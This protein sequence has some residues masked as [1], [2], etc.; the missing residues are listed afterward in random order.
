MSWRTVVISSNAKLDY[1]IGYMVVRGEKT[2]KI[3][4][5]EIGMLIVESTAVSMTSYLLSELMKNKIKVVFCDEK[6][7][8]CSELVSYYGSHDTSSKIRKQIEWTKDDKDHIWTEIVSEKIKQQAL[9]LQRYQKEEAN[10]LFE[11]MEEVEFGDITNREGHAAKVYFNT[12][13]GKKFTRTDENPINAALNYGY[14]IILSIFNREIVS[15]GYLTQIGLFHDNMFNQFNLSSDLMEPFRPLVDQL[16]VELK[17][18]KFE[19]EEKRKMLELLNKEVEICGKMEVVTNA[20]K[21]YCRSV[22]DALNDRDISLIRF[23]YNEL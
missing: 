7:N 2:T 17:P 23:Y 6:R 12:L 20:I 3:H 1:Q 8:P 4:L 9:M 13:F 14:G 15:S 22:F 21:I 18:E 10:M 16:V 5:N 19:T 11:Y